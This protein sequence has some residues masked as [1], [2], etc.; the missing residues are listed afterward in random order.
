MSFSSQFVI[1]A[2]G[3][4]TRMKSRLPK[5]LHEIGNLPLL[6]HVVA[7]ANAAGSDRIS[8][9]RGPN[10]DGLADALGDLADGVSFP[11]QTER[12]GTA[13]AVLAARDDLADPA[14]AVFVL[15]ADTPLL[16]LE[17]VRAVRETLEGGID[18]VVVGF[19][20]DAPAGYGRLIVEDGALERIVEDKDAS[21]AEKLVTL[22]NSGIMAFRGEHVL[23]ILDAVG[24][25][26]A[27][28]EYYLTDA[29]A[30][31]RER[32]LDVAVA[33]AGESEV[34]GVNTRAQ[35]ARCE[36][37]FQDRRRAAAMLDGVTLTGPETVFFSHDTEIGADVT[38]EPNVVFGP[39][40]SIAESATIRAFSHLEG[41]R[42][43][44]GAVIGPYARIR[45]GSHI[46]EGA[47]V[48]NFVETKNTSIEAGAKA[49]HLAYLG[50][51][52]I[53]AR[54]NVGAGTITCNYDG[55]TKSLTDIGASA[56]IGS[57]SA[58][59]A[60]VRIGAG[61]YVASGSVITEDVPDDALAF[62]R[63]RQVN[64]PGR[65]PK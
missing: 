46:G 51:A 2:A 60:P 22:C 62:G 40:V 61:A 38:V 3:E 64:K 33:L 31:T 10:S 27:Q 24:N 55:K 20:T 37:V 25:D 65:A 39:G 13:H 53:G 26:N 32:G 49:N 28:A 8:V 12:L 47:K 16:T 56:F 44:A 4:G 36:A 29:V 18:L 6:G 5:V 7:L 42:I 50:D 52:R 54:A 17:T 15:F 41:A 23:P 45:P 48:G 35:L 63:A 21:E 57:N 1:L 9:V 43:E 34:M 59:V 19:E 30:I 11:V 14:D 58:L